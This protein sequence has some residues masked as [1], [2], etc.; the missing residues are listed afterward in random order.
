[1]VKMVFGIVLKKNGKFI[2]DEFWIAR[3]FK[4]PSDLATLLQ[5]FRNIAIYPHELVEPKV[6]SSPSEENLCLD[7]EKLCT[8]DIEILRLSHSFI[9]VFTVFC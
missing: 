6:I 2:F 8:W 9:L 3:R 4:K 1:M 5:I 7:Q